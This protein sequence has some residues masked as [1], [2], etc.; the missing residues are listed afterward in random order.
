M[1][2]RKDG[3]YEN[4][5]Y[6]TNFSHI[7]IVTPGVFNVSFLPTGACVGCYKVGSLEVFVVYHEN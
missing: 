1:N 3:G 4:E 5:N 2:V 6:R 7:F